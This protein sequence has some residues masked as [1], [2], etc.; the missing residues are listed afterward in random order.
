MTEQEKAFTA[1]EKLMKDQIKKAQ[2][3]LEVKVVKKMNST[4]FTLDSVLNCQIDIM[5]KS[6]WITPYF[7]Y[8]CI[9]ARIPHSG[10]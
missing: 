10:R 9:Y 3:T 5:L 1:F 8:R 4:I 6:F 2:A 7:P